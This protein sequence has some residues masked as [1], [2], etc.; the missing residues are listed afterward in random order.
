M[1]NEK[2][3]IY[4]QAHKKAFAQAKKKLPDQKVTDIIEYA[5]KLME[6]KNPKEL[7]KEI[8]LEYKDFAIEYAKAY[9]G[10]MIDITLSKADHEALQKLA[11]KKLGAS[12]VKFSL[13]AEKSIEKYL[14]KK[15]TREELIDELYKDGLKDVSKKVIQA[16]ELDQLELKQVPEQVVKALG[17]DAQMLKEHPEMVLKMS[18]P[19]VSYNAFMGAYKELNK[20]LKDLELAREERMV[21]EAEC[22]HTVDMI[23]QS[24]KEMEE[25][26]S[27]YLSSHIEMFEAGFSAMDEA[28]LANDTDGFIKGNVT[29]QKALGYDVQ[30]TNQEEFDDLMDSDEAFKF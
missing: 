17:I 29:I 5:K 4:A 2:K 6:E 20:A 23:V 24:R 16:F 11:K 28:I 12:L 14:D 9:A 30:F 10:S 18:L 1:D 25:R 27:E 26:V 8:G 22:R 15:I 7:F 19:I 13:K 3:G 21:I